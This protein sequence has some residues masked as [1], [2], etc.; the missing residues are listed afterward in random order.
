MRATAPP[1]RRTFHAPPS[2]PSFGITEAPRRDRSRVTMR[3]RWGLWMRRA[4]AATGR[5]RMAAA[6]QILEVSVRAEAGRQAF[7]VDHL[8]AEERPDR[9]GH[10]VP[11]ALARDLLALAPR[12]RFPEGD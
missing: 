4:T 2:P 6:E 12:D 11:V 7:G 1:E 8:I 5:P 10:G 3:S 9:G